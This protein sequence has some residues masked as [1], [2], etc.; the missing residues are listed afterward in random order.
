MTSI[1]KKDRRFTVQG[2]GKRIL[3]EKGHVDVHMTLAVVSSATA[4]AWIKS[5]MAS[6]VPLVLMQHHGVNK[7]RTG[8]SV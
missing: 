2:F 3:L 5:I 4:T 7:K 6:V 8:K 1:R